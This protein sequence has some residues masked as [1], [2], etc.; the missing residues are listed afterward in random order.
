MGAG[1]AECCS[2]QRLLVVAVEFHG[3]LDRY[4]DTVESEE[5]VNVASH[6][7]FYR[8]PVVFRPPNPSLESR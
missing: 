5:N 1:V 3:V 6:P 8:T 7:T 2:F 4:F